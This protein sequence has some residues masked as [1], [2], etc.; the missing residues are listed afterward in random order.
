MV[1]FSDAE[2]Q[3]LL[4]CLSAVSALGPSTCAVTSRGETSGEGCGDPA[5]AVVGLGATVEA[6]EDFLNHHSG[7]PQQQKQQQQQEPL[8]GRG[9]GAVSGAA[10]VVPPR[11]RLGTALEC[12]VGFGVGF[13]SGVQRL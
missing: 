7:H 10:V 3:L 12:A 6:F 1:V 13:G 8:A 5:V 2:Q 4:L 9:E 11:V